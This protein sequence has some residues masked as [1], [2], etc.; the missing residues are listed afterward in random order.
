MTFN[1]NRDGAEGPFCAVSGAILNTPNG[2]WREPSIRLAGDGRAYSSEIL[3]KVGNVLFAESDLISDPNGVE[4]SRYYFQW[5][6]VAGGASILIPSATRQSYEVRDF[7]VGKYLAVEAT[8]TDGLGVREAVYGAPI[9]PVTRQ[10]VDPREPPTS[11]VELLGTPL[12][13]IPDGLFIGK[14]VTANTNGVTNDVEYLDPDK[15]KDGLYQWFT[16]TRPSSGT[17]RVVEIQDATGKD[18]DLGTNLFDQP[19]KISIGHADDPNQRVESSWTERVAYPPVAAG[20]IKVFIGA[21]PAGC[22]NS[23]RKDTPRDIEVNRPGLTLLAC[24]DPSGY[25]ADTESY[26]WLHVTGGTQPPYQYTT[27]SGAVDT[28]YTI[29]PSDEGKRIAVR[30]DYQDPR[31]VARSSTSGPVGVADGGRPTITAMGPVHIGVTL[32]ANLPVDPAGIETSTVRHQW[33]RTDSTTVPLADIPDATAS[34][35]TL[36]EADEGK[37]LAVKVSY[38]DMDGTKEESVSALQPA[39]Y[40]DSEAT[41][42]P[43]ITGV[44][45]IGGTLTT[46][47]A[48]VMD[49][50][51]VPDDVHK[52][53]DW[54]IFSASG[55]YHAGGQDSYAP[56]SRL[57][58]GIAGGTEEANTAYRIGVDE[59]GSQIVV[60]LRDGWMDSLGNLNRQLVSSPTAFVRA[61]DDNQPATGKVTL[62]R[63]AKITWRLLEIGAILESRGKCSHTGDTGEVRRAGCIAQREDTTAV[64]CGGGTGA[65]ARWNRAGG[66]GDGTVENH[67]RRRL[68]GTRRRAG[69]RGRFGPVAQ[70]GR[71][72]QVAAGS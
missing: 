70:S 39:T 19:V 15:M 51:G 5:V 28:W 59:A 68:A 31:Y 26:K 13:D 62:R 25:R 60:L 69:R 40:D 56:G 53:L 3:A 17:P 71:R 66:R 22:K 2:R 37:F 36:V 43:T 45:K 30:M 11:S 65:R 64:G 46:S 38:T 9:G 50:N 6:H 57:K 23:M 41:G 63:L 42:R 7:D 4:N 44:A 35:Y 24:H 29:R 21:R 1:D 47:T 54:H 8:Y 10:P 67:D 33:Q 55:D 18:L 49:Q 16:L 61:A 12:I 20:G 72:P 34:T 58:Q 27:I 14:T 52:N 48:Q 32:T